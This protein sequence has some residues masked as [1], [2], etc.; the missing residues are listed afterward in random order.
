[1]LV[2]IQAT[3]ML[4]I[5]SPSTLST[6][7]QCFNLVKRP[8]LL[9]KHLFKVLKLSLTFQ[10]LMVKI[11]VKVS[12]RLISVPMQVIHQI[13]LYIA[14]DT[15]CLQVANYKTLLVSTTAHALFVTTLVCL[16]MLMEMLI[17]LMDVTENWLEL[18]GV[19]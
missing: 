2:T 12:Y 9:Q 6:L 11:R 18:S 17:S 8:H 4:L 3:I 15:T 7:A 1:M 14:V 13:L 19:F 5:L 16:L 10:G